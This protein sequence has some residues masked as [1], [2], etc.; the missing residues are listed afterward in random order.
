MQ[1]FAMP[2][3]LRLLYEPL[4]SDH[5]AGLFE[6]LEDPRVYEHINDIP[7]PGV[8]QLAARFARMSS[9]PPP[10]RTDECWLNY[11]LRL[12]ANGTLIGR[13]QATI[14]ERRAEVAYL[15]GPEYWGQGYATEAM[16]AFQ[17]DLRENAQVTEFWA[18]T[19]P[20]NF[21]SVHLLERLGYV[22][23]G[24]SWPALLSYE[25]GDLVFVLR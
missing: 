3:S 16:S 22:Q 19:A 6:A 12:K 25:S 18:T 1:Q 14:R 5:A 13:L 17:V 4:Y 24:D 15:L 9:G 7:S 10:D 20:Q 23:I 2:G 11:A 21:R 8:A